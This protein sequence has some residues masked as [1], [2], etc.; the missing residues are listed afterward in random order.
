MMFVGDKGKILAGFRG[1]SARLIPEQKMRDYRA[2]KNFPE[3]PAAQRGQGFGDAEWVAGF[4]EGRPT[5]GD[6]LLAGPISDAFNLAAVS[7]R[8]DG[9]RLLFDSQTAKVTNA[10]E[11]NKYLTRE[12]RAGWELKAD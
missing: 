1:E 9:R 8:M 3:A 7:L 5:Y 12:Y 11:A 6:F 2:L 10:P 4:R